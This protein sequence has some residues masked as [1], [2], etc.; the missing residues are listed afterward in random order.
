MWEAS[1]EKNSAVINSK[2]KEK[3]AKIKEHRG[4]VNMK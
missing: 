3:P 4:G 2:W 1:W